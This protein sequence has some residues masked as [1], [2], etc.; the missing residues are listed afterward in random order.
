[1]TDDDL[2]GFISTQEKIIK[3]LEEQYKN[4][5]IKKEK[6][7]KNIA[8]ANLQIALATVIQDEKGSSS[9]SSDDKPQDDKA[10]TSSSN[11]AFSLPF[12]NI[13]HCI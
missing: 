4:S 10:S 9:T 7:D 13:N 11:N 6:M 12:T 5:V 2:K 1:M 8:R 3:R